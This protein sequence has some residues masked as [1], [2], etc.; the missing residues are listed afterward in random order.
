LRIHWPVSETQAI[1]SEKDRA[2]PLL[3]ELPAYF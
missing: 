3:E 2:L 1:L